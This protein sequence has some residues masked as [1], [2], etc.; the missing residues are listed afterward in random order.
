VRPAVFS[1]KK[2]V[3]KRLISVYPSWILSATIP[4]PIPISV[5]ITIAV[6]V[7]IPVTIAVPITIAVAVSI[8]AAVVAIT[9]AT[10]AGA[11]TVMVIVATIAGTIGRINHFS[12]WRLIA[13][14]GISGI[15]AA[16]GSSF[17]LL[18]LLY[19]F[20]GKGRMNL[21]GAF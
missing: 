1:A 12:R 14:T 5:P 13:V 17:V 20:F 8:P 6:A 4:I 18:D 19:F 11:G 10:V 7:S 3:Q 2:P 21:D 9:I 16:F 15:A